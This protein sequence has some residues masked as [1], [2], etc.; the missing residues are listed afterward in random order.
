MSTWN[1]RVMVTLDSGGD[2]W[3][4]IHEVHYDDNGV[5]RLYSE[6]EAK[7]SG[8]DEKELLWLLEQMRK[9]VEKP[10]LWMGKRFP[11]EYVE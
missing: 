4:E 7:V 8:F 10:V 2:P 5:P 3:F 9:A 1:H 11:E 6:N